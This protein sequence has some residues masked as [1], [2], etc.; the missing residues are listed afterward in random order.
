MICCWM[1]P[2]WM[3]ASIHPFIDFHYLLS[4][5]VHPVL[6]WF[7]GMGV[8]EKQHSLLDLP[9]P[10]EFFHISWRLLPGIPVVL[11]HFEICL[12]KHKRMNTYKH[13]KEHF[14]KLLSQISQWSFYCKILGVMQCLLHFRSIKQCAPTPPNS[15][16][17]ALHCR[18]L[19]SN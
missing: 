7:V 16:T 2:V 19:A 12:W 5:H 11:W 13:I 6:H 4:M 10:W 1:N 8:R 18:L 14:N 3:Q 17:S 15:Q 9:L